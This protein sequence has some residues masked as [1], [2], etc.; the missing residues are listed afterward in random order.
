MGDIVRGVASS[1]SEPVTQVRP[2]T[3]SASIRETV[4]L[5]WTAT[6]EALKCIDGPIMDAFMYR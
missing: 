2:T 3:I 5:Y 4:Q 6:P 1:Y